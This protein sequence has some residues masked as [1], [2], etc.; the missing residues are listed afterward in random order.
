MAAISQKFPTKAGR[1]PI[2]KSHPPNFAHIV[3]EQVLQR[4]LSVAVVRAFR[5]LKVTGC[6]PP[7]RR[8]RQQGG[9]AGNSTSHSYSGSITNG[10]FANTNHAERMQP[11]NDG[12]TQGRDTDEG[13]PRE[14]TENKAAGGER[15][16]SMVP[17][18]GARVLRVW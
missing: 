8:S 10:S 16:E 3:E 15:R 11:G 14:E 9:T 2:S 6:F 4:D 18:Q 17:A 12:C 1:T 7:G 5:R 13:A